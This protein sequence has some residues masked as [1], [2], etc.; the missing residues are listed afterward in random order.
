MEIQHPIGNIEVSLS[1]NLRL[2][3]LETINLNISKLTL[4][5]RKNIADKTE[6]ERRHLEAT[7]WKNET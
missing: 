7:L 4:L 2:N 6:L 5:G 1:L 3:D